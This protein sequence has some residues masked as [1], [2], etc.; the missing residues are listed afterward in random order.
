MQ[1]M[2]M[3]IGIKPDKIKEYK[4][5]HADAWPDVLDQIRGSNIR[6]YTIFLREPEN[7]LFGYWEYHGDDFNGDMAQMAKDPRTQEWW[8][9][10]DPCQSPLASRAEGEQWSMMEEVFHTE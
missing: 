8:T 5:L 7:L 6:N 3:V 10:T 9:H 2:G 1:R 4:R